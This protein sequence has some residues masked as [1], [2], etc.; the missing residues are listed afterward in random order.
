MA[1]NAAQSVLLT[2]TTPAPFTPTAS[3]TISGND[4]IPG[5]GCVMRVVTGGTNA[6]SVSVLDPNLTAQGNAGTVTP[7]TVP[8][9][10]VRYILIPVSAV[11]PATGVATV[12]FGGTLT[13]T[14]YD[15]IKF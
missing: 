14:T 5:G 11:N 1:L 2:G 13:G 8:T 12:T 4:I 6:A 3:D 15:L 10:S 9:S 7:V